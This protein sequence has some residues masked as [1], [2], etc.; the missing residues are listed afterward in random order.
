MPELPE[1]ESIRK[2]LSLSVVGS[3]INNI[4]V[5]KPKI[6]SSSSNIRSINMTKVKELQAIA[7][8]K[9]L[10][11]T[12]TAKN[13]IIHLD[14]QQVI[15]VHLKMTGQLLYSTSDN[16]DFI[17]KH[18]CVIFRLDNG[19]MVYNDIRQFGYVLLFSSLADMLNAG[20]LQNLG[21][22]PYTDTLDY[23]DI[24]QLLKKYS[25]S[26]KSVFLDQRVVTGL[27]NIYA[28]EVC[29]ASR[30]SPL[31][32]ANSLSL[33]QVKN[34]TESIVSI[35]SHSISVGGSSISDYRLSDGSRGGYVQ[36]HQVYGRKGLTCNNCG[37]L[38]IA[39]KIG[40]R[41]TVYCTLCQVA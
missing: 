27:G 24:H 3:T 16:P 5:I 10:N 15:L 41:T 23:Q 33:S 30:I 19:I 31:I 32:P 14:N 13:I 4:E 18:T 40:G 29:H 28:D 2:G 25:K 6:V 39:T 21:L 12:R 34:M 26:I 8:S 1:V 9:I 20:H 35:I 38:L 17:N 36:Y 11:I 37:N 22:D 7:G